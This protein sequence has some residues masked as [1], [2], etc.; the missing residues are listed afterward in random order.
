MPAQTNRQ[1]P[2]IISWNVGS[3]IDPIEKKKSVMVCVGLLDSCNS[4]WGL[5]IAQT[6]F[7]LKIDFMEKLSLLN[8]F[9]T[10]SP[11]SKAKML[12]D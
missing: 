5:I 1:V 3:T 2:I 9:G 10:D 12:V 6:Q 4:E 11:T 7:Y 8:L